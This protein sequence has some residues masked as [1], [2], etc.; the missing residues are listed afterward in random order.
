M[1]SKHPLD[2]PLN[3]KLTL[4]EIMEALRL[5]I[6]AELDAVNLYLQLARSIDDEK[7][8]R[9]FEDIANEE[10]THIGEFLAV[11]ESLDPQQV[12]ELKR[13]AEEVRELT[14]IS[15][16]QERGAVGVDS[17]NSDRSNTSEDPQGIELVGKIFLNIVNE[18]RSLRKYIP[19]VDLGKGVESVVLEKTGET[20]QRIVVPLRELSVYFRITQRSLEYSYRTKTSIDAPDM[21]QAA[22]KLATMEDS[23]IIGSILDSN[24]VSR[25]KLSDW[26]TEDAPVIDVVNAVNKLYSAGATRPFVLVINPANYVNMVKSTG[27][28]GLTELDRVR[29]IV[30]HIVV[31]P[32]IG[33]DKAIVLSAKPY[34]IDVVTGGDISVDYIGP[35]KDMHVFRAWELIALRIKHGGGIIVLER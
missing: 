4:D 26:R 20:L 28:T 15:S 33:E 29:Q 9:V 21:Y 32:V 10:K 7:V 34:V 19:V 23:L 8:R 12:E 22:L 35:E 17:K 25:S 6:I 18:T 24:D 13:G 27:R 3:R 2:L 1:M 31:S 5:S 11:L 16:P 14:G 30:D